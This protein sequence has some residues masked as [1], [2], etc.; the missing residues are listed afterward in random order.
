M[1]RLSLIMRSHL[2]NPHILQNNWP[3]ISICVKVMRGRWELL[4]I[5]GI[6]RDVTTK[7]D[8]E[9][10]TGSFGHEGHY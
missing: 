5:G 6:L 8:A 10:W 7:C 1:H 2:K 9:S 3:V 4:Q